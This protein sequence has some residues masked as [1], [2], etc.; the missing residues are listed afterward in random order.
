MTTS[1]QGPF[2]LVVRNGKVITPEGAMAAD[3][4]MHGE[5]IVAVAPGLHGHEEIDASGCL[6]IPGGVD[7]HVHLQM[8]L[9][10]VVS[11][12]TFRSGTMAAALGGTT[13]VVDFVHTPAGGSML[14]ALAARR[15]EADG[16]VAIDYGLHMEIPTWHAAEVERLAEIP[17]VRDAG[18][19]TF[20]LYQ[21][22]PGVILDDPSLYRALQAVGRVGGLA[23]VHSEVGPVLDVLRA[24]ALAAGRI[25]PIEHERTRPAALEATAIHRAAA[26]AHQ[27]DCPILIFHVGNAPALEAIAAQRAAGVE[28]WG[29]SCPQYLMLTA[30]EHL[31]GAEGALY[32]CAPPLRSAADRD[33][34]WRALA[35]G[36]LQ[37]V[38]T[39]HCPWT[40]AEKAQPTF[41][42]VPGGV[43]SIEARLALLYS[44]GV[45][46]GRL[47]AE[48]WVELCCQAP[49]RLMGLERKGRLAPG[50]DAD[51]VIFDPHA[52]RTL[53][54]APATRTLHE[55]A[56]W[57]P[58]EGIEVHGWP[59]DVLLRGRPVVRDGA[60]VGRPGDGRFVQRR[61][62][63]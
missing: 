11:T 16:E 18:C 48:R 51:V 3:V 44:A 19:A 39:D 57:T 24:E 14:E 49:A 54:Q 38:S 26:I 1:A 20:K 21:A 35:D 31:G 33:A 37:V 5:E 63:S 29:E 43:P 45:R 22:Y 59:R 60:Y 10:D 52:T 42:T 36:T 40:R 62:P 7:Q 6:V 13:T 8:R 28:I 53:S 15:A 25:A 50:F 34:V 4:A 47:S 27:A 55:A 56:D 23:V 32:I 12:D 41:A 46:T 2:D 9:G 17:A 61:L 30:E 58:Y